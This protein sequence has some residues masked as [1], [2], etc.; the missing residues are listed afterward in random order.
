MAN[1]ND[2]AGTVDEGRERRFNESAC[3]AIKVGNAGCWEIKVGRGTLHDYATRDR[4]GE[5]WNVRE[6][7]GLQWLAVNDQAHSWS[8]LRNPFDVNSLQLQSS[9][10]FQAVCDDFSSFMAL[11]NYETNSLVVK[12]RT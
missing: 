9:S 3:E 5:R 6:D 2:N 4:T 7:C 1:P 8:S 12:G 11:H 10:D